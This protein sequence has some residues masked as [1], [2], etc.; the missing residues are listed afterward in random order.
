LLV[1]VLVRGLA[2]TEVYDFSLP[3]WAIVMFSVLIKRSDGCNSELSHAYES[4]IDNF[5]ENPLKC[6]PIV[7]IE[8]R[9]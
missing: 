2:D 7:K 6:H 9:G 1:F 3:L 4:R 5:A 8:Y